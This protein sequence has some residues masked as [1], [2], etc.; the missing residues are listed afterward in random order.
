MWERE[1]TFG[2][3]K[4]LN[5]LLLLQGSCTEAEVFLQILEFYYIL[6]GKV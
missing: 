1:K 5:I 3:F 6:P 2:D 4:I